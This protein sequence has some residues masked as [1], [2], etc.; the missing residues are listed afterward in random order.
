LPRALRLSSPQI[1]YR[2]GDRLSHL[3]AVETNVAPEK[4]YGDRTPTNPSLLAKAR[5]TR[6]QF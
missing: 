3:S 2:G 1:W 6:S 5:L 4:Y